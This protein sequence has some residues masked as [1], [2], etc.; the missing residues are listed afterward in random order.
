[1]VKNAAAQLSLGTVAE[2]MVLRRVQSKASGICPTRQTPGENVIGA[3]TKHH[4]KIK[5]IEHLQEGIKP[6][7]GI[8][9]ENFEAI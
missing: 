7:S 2:L 4:D 6:A 9:V 3:S 1:M 8:Q 5:D